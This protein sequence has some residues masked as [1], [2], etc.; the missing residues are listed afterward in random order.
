MGTDESVDVGLGAWTPPAL[1][2]DP[3]LEP[4][5]SKPWADIQGPIEP[6][7]LEHTEDEAE[8]F[9]LRGTAYAKDVSV[10]QKYKGNILKL[11]HD[12]YTG[13]VYIE[14]VTASSTDR[15]DE[16]TEFRFHDGRMQDITEEKQVYTYR[17]GLIK[18]EKAEAD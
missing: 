12:V 5:D 16:V 2:D 8:V 9:T 13:L 3:E 6:A 7:E 17:V 1:Y 18:V 14:S 4:Q 10:L 15:R 11:R